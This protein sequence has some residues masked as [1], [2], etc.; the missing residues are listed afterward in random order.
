MYGRIVLSVLLALVVVALLAGIGFYAYNVGIAQGMVDSGKLAAPTTGMP[1]SPY[2][3]GRFFYHPFGFGFLGCLMPLL[4]FFLVFALLRGIF[5]RAHWGGHHRHWEKGY[6]P[7][8]D[9][10]HRKMHES[11]TTDK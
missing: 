7:M 6:P 11:T 4:A 8:L 3:G 2:Y 5:W 1:P 10:W 9:E